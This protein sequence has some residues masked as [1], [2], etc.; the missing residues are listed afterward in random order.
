MQKNRALAKIRNGGIT[1]GPA[2]GIDS[3]DL[4]EQV[5]HVGFDFV[6][7]DWQHGQW[8]ELSLNNALARFL[9]TDTVP[10]VRVKGQEPGTINRVL[11][12]GA[13]GVIVP[14]V[15]TAEQAAAA[16]SPAFYPP[17]GNRSGG[18]IRLG[19]IGGGTAQD[20]F[21]AANDEVIVIV[22]V[23]SEEAIANVESIM[24][25]ENVDVVLIGPGDLMIN[26]HAHGHDEAH[27]EALVQ[28]VAAAS[29]R[30]GKAAGY[31]CQSYE[32]AQ[33]RVAE[34]FRFLWFG[35]DSVFVSVG[36]QNLR[37]EIETLG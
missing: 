29:K 33:Q 10:I 9:H 16:A 20:Y 36:M 17:K 25:V 11:D 4:A 1:A 37:E 15:E 13:M 12:M 34:G 2:M 7:F 28:E 35:N 8:T 31:V 27:H 21:S 22:M 5:A 32:Q 26:V 23:E 24:Q 14:M 6:S 30:T 19:L 3:P 18:G